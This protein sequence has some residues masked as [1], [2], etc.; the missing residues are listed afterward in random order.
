MPGLIATLGM[1]QVAHGIGF[2]ITKGFTLTRMVDPFK[3]FGQGFVPEGGFPVAGIIFIVVAVI[4]YLVWE[5]TVYGKS[6]RATG[7]NP[8]AAYLAGVKIKTMQLS[9]Y[10]VSGMLAAL[11]GIIRTSRVM[12]VSF[13]SFLG[14]E[15]DSIA[16]AVIG[17]ISLMG[18]KGNIIGVVL[19]ALIIGVLSNGM[20]ILGADPFLEDT[21]LGVLVIGAV[22]IDYIRRR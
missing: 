5:Y 22:S 10:M 14:M 15:L 12:S 2:E 6:V 20:N 17:G 11:G 21:I 3:Q 13:Q 16:S 1:W 4:C 8:S 7:G 9:A 18:G 19:G